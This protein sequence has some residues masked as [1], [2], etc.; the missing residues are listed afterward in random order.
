MAGC[1]KSVARCRPA[2]SAAIRKCGFRCEGARCRSIR[3]V[4]T[5]ERL[6]LKPAFDLAQ[7]ATSGL[8]LSA[9]GR[10]FHASRARGTGD[11][12]G[13]AVSDFAVA[14][15][16]NPAL[17]GKTAIPHDPSA[18]DRG[19]GTLRLRR[20]RRVTGTPPESWRRRGLEHGIHSRRRPLRSDQA[21]RDCRS[22]RGYGDR[23]S[24]I[25]QVI[26][27]GAAERLRDDG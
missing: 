5:R 6:P 20:Y 3:E 1:V 21:E 26:T 23:F 15:S 7:L 19:G 8:Y 14:V 16:R 24:D 25:V 11:V 27:I 4:S 17:H 2:E 13:A 22:G 10:P 9:P 12:C 18:T